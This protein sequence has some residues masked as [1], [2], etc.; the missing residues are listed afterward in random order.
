MA[1]DVI[2]VLLEHDLQSLWS[3]LC[4]YQIMTFAGSRKSVLL[5]IQVLIVILVLVLKYDAQP[6]TILFLV[7]GEGGIGEW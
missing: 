6:L 1:D 4:K 5:F 3:F 7:V 2:F